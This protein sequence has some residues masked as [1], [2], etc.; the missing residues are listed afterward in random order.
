MRYQTPDWI[1]VHRDISVGGRKGAGLW[2]QS[3]V[4]CII[5][6]APWLYLVSCLTITPDLSWHKQKESKN[7][8]WCAHGGTQG[9]RGAGLA[10]LPGILPH[11]SLLCA[12]FTCPL[13]FLGATRQGTAAFPWGTWSSC[14]PSPQVPTLHSLPGLTSSPRSNTSGLYVLFCQPWGRTTSVLLSVKV[15]LW[16]EGVQALLSCSY[17]DVRCRL[18]LAFK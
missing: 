2:K 3:P 15:L 7:W 10:R 5:A 1:R 9:K 8:Q 4:L 17:H 12:S 6:C 16:V 18:I 14:V 13:L 11:L